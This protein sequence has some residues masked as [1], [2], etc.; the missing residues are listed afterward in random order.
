M[1]KIVMLSSCNEFPKTFVQELQLIGF[2]RTV[3]IRNFSLQTADVDKENLEYLGNDVDRLELI[4]RAG[5]DRDQHS[6]F[7][8]ATP[9]DHDHEAKPVDLLP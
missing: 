9:H 4:N 3:L 5:T 6:A 1:V 8:N 7:W 2:Q